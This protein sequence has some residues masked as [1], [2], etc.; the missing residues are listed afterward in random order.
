M[1]IWD[2][3]WKNFGSEIRDGKNLDP[4]I[5]IPD[6]RHW[7]MSSSFLCTLQREGSGRP[8]RLG[9]LRDGGG[10]PGPRCPCQREPRRLP[11]ADPRAEARGADGAG[12]AGRVGLRPDGER[13]D[14]R[15]PPPGDTSAAPGAAGRA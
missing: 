15:L 14:G 3:G 2:P 5:N 6:P 9:N 12:W 11:E 10:R 8:G 13:Q 4:G 7:F 1:R